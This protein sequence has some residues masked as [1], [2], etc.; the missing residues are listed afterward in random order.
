MNLRRSRGRAK[1]V[2]GFIFALAMASA[3][4][5]QDFQF[6]SIL[7]DG[8][9]RIPDA[10]IVSVADVGRGE[11]VTAAELNDVVLRLQ[12]SGLF[13]TVEIIPNGGQLTIR[14]VEYPSINRVNIEGNVRL[15]DEQLLAALQSAPRDIYSPT[16]AE[17]DAR[18]IA[19]AY[20]CLLYTSDAADE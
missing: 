19:D 4:S 11:V 7:V 20:A 13:E 12:A 6:S 15:S 17:E 8:N 5:A 3:A 18:A 10:T 16:T 9:E 1:A 14:V 2:I